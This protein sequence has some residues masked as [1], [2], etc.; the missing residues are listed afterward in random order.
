M[1]ILDE[2]TFEM[3]NPSRFTTFTFPNPCD[4][5]T[6]SLLRVAVLDSPFQP[7][8]DPPRVAA[9]LVPKHRHSDWIFST[10][11][12][13]LHHL[14]SSPGISRLILIGDSS[15][16]SPPIYRRP[17]KDDDT[18]CDDELAVS[19]KPLFLALSPK[20]CFKHGIPEIPILSYEDNLISS[21][22]LEKCVGCLVGEMVVEDVEIDCGGE[23]SKR[24]FR[25][26]LRFKRMPNLIQTEVRIVPKMGFG[27]DCV[28]IGQV[29]FRLDDSV[30]VHSYLV[31]MVASL[32]LA[33]PYIEGRIRSGVRPK[34][35]CLG[36]GGGALL[37]FMRTQLGFQ[38]VGVEADEEVLSV[39]RRYFGL[40]DGEHIKVCVG[41][42][43][44][45]IEKLAGAC[46][47]EVG[48]D[49]GRGNDVNTKFDVILVDLD[50]S[51][52][53]DGLIA[54]PLEFVR[55]P[56]LLSARSIL[57][58]NGILAINVI[59]PNTSF[60]KTLVHEFRDVFNDLYE[61]D[62]GNGENFILIAVA[63][64]LMPSS[65]CENCFL[66]KLGN[67]ISGAYLNSIKKI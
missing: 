29:E 3:I 9:M 8:A 51:D 46:E 20:S 47:V 31:P 42:A 30:L 44:E 50:S 58:D 37:G 45:F 67:A 12:G 11:S 1:A 60:Y 43:L 7:P 52:A 48:C 65:D 15:H 34:A 4:S 56:V 21:L 32:S 57:C 63:S 35:L 19:L 39:S 41:D 26:R 28:G 24:E 13:H 18:S 53:R 17:L 6:T 23:V 59:P 10:H 66:T 62:V 25:R 33:A 2:T 49:V 14:L 16:H 55:K 5:T 64:P 61:I 54:P 27:L 40:E 38:V 22:V 36:V